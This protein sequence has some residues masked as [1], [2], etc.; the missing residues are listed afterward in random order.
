MDKTIPSQHVVLS[1]YFSASYVALNGRLV[2][3][4][5]DVVGGHARYRCSPRNVKNFPPE[6]THFAHRILLLL[7][8]YGDLVPVGKQLL[9]V[10][11]PIF[12]I[13]WEFYALWHFSSR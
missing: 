7:V 3:D 8:Q 13:V 2:H 11:Y 6:P 5:V 4:L 9:R 1:T 12:R 10:R